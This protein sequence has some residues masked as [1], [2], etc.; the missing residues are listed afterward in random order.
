MKRDES[1]NKLKT[2]GGMGLKSQR[3]RHVLF[4]LQI[5]YA[6]ASLAVPFVLPFRKLSTISSRQIGPST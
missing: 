4:Y 2:C 3:V 1:T 6:C 5:V